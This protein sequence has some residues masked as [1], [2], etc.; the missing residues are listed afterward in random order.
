MPD[1]SINPA[2]YAL[3]FCFD[4]ISPDALARATFPGVFPGR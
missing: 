2:R 4:S 3:R 1:A